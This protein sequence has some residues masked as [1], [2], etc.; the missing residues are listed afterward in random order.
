[1]I[2]LG[3]LFIVF[4]ICINNKIEY[5]ERKEFFVFL[6][7]INVYDFITMI[8][9]GFMTIYAGICATWVDLLLKHNINF[10]FLLL[11]PED[12]IAVA[13]KAGLR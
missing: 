10:C 1:M 7:M 4:E 2:V 13:E 11:R 8:I 5:I 6:S 3:L 9:A 12:L